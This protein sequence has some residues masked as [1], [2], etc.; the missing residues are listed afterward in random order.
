MTVVTFLSDFGTDD[1]F[2]GICHGVILR[3]CPEAQV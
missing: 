3:S 1:D 2:V